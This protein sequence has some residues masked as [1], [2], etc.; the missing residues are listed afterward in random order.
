MT[1]HTT[2]CSS[3]A[4]HPRSRENSAIMPGPIPPSLG[5]RVDVGRGGSS[6]AR[7]AT[8]R[9]TPPS[10]VHTWTAIGA[11]PCRRAFDVSYSS[12]STDS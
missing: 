6:A 5:S 12:A 7:S 9:S 2:L 10:L 3:A 11:R 4:N 8:C 1:A